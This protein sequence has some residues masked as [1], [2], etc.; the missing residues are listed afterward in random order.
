MPWAS[1]EQVDLSLLDSTDP[2]IRT[3]LVSLAKKALIEDGFLFVTG[4]GVSDATLERQ[5]AIAQLALEDIPDEE[6]RLYAARLDEGSYRGY[7]P[8]GIWERD[9]VK[10]NIEVRLLILL[11]SASR[12]WLRAHPL[13]LY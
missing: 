12:Q 6:K 7:K 2:A 8:L 4:T 11:P 10:D 5:L 9:G 3:R 1:L 13:P